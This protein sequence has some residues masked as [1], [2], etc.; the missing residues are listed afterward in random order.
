MTTPIRIL[1]DGGEIEVRT[2]SKSQSMGI[3]SQ[4][5]QIAHLRWEPRPSALAY[6]D[7]DERCYALIGAKQ[8]IGRRGIEAWWCGEAFAR[9]EIGTL[10]RAQC[11]ATRSG[12]IYEFRRTGYGVLLERGEQGE[13]ALMIGR[14]KGRIGRQYTVHPSSRSEE[15]HGGVLAVVMYY[16][17]WSDQNSRIIS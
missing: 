9:L 10:G 8:R 2:A 11:V 3:Y 6:F 4:G 13:V 16:M 12:A 7:I 5:Q 15:E 1:R 14:R 17:V